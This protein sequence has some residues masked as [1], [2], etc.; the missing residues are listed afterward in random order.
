MHDQIP[1]MPMPTQPPRIAIVFC[2]HDR[3]H[4]GWAYDYTHLAAHFIATG[5]Y[6]PETG[7]SFSLSMNWCQTSLLPEGR[8][9][10]VEDLYRKGIAKILWWDT[11]TRAPKEG[12]HMLLRHDLPIV[13]CNYPS[14]RPPFR[15]TA[16]TIDDP[17]RIM[18]TRPGQ[19]GL[20]EASHVGFGFCLTDISVFGDPLGDDAPMFSFDWYKCPDEHK[21]KIVGEDVSFARA[22]RKRGHK[23][24]VDHELSNSIG[25]IG[26]FE[27]NTEVMQQVEA[28][29][30]GEAAAVAA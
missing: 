1:Q 8:H 24:F 2:S 3:V 5:G 13:G 10:L 27:Y 23:I 19:T 7:K 16:A 22:A 30:V 25:H 21:W 15:F 6:V 29:A 18:E 4:A 14:R 12:L 17:P 26:E 11:D 20:Q 28:A 9:R